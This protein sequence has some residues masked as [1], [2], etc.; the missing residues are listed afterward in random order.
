MKSE[1][2]K[3]AVGGGWSNGRTPDSESVCRGSNPL[4][5]ARRCGGQCT[6]TDCLKRFQMVRGSKVL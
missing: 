6:A 1:Y 3:L 2:D 5:P 4:P